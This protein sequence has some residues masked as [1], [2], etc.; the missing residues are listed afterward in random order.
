MRRAAITTL[1]AIAALGLGACTTYDGYGHDGYGHDGYGR[2]GYGGYG[3]EGVDYGPHHRGGHQGRLT[4]PGAAV[5]DPW[6]SGTEEGTI[7]VTTGW[8][9]ARQGFVSRDVA[10]RANVW[11]RR[12]ADANRNRRLTDR[13]IRLALIQASRNYRGRR[14]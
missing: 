3:Y 10:R 7:I 5:L 8:G 11:F 1:A 6:L 4:G 14:Y 13:E 2:G 9:S 12:Y